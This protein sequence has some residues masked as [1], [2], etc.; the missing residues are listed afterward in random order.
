MTVMQ[1]LRSNS[2]KVTW[3][4]LVPVVLAFTMFG[5]GLSLDAVF[6][7]EK[8]KE[9]YVID[10]V[11]VTAEEHHRTQRIWSAIRSV[12]GQASSVS[13]DEVR[14]IIGECI[15][16]KKLGFVVTDAE[17]DASIYKEFGGSQQSYEATLRRMGLSGDDIRLWFQ[18]K[19][20]REKYS[21][22]QRSAIVPTAS[23]IYKKFDYDRTNY[24]IKY[25][26]VRPEDFA[27]DVI[28][29][30]EKL[31]EFYDSAVAKWNT[32][33]DKRVELKKLQN[34]FTA[35]EEEIKALKEEVKKLEEDEIIKKCDLVDGPFATVHFVY[36]G[37]EDVKK[38]VEV[39]SMS[40][41]VKDFYFGRLD[42]YRK[43]DLPAVPKYGPVAPEDPSIMPPVPANQPTE[44]P[45]N[46]ATQPVVTPENPDPNAPVPTELPDADNDAING[47]GEAS[48]E[49]KPISYRDFG[50]EFRTLDEVR[51]QVV[52][53]LID[54]KSHDKSEEILTEV[55]SL[56]AQMDLVK[57]DFSIIDKQL[58]KKL[59]SKFPFKIDEKVITPQNAEFIETYGSTDL[60]LR[61]FDDYSYW[62][63]FEEDHL[64]NFS[65]V[66]TVASGKYIF[67]VKKEERANI[68]SFEDTKTVVET[69]YRKIEQ[70]RIAKETAEN[71]IKSLQS[72]KEIGELGPNITWA[73]AKGTKATILYLR[74]FGSTGFKEGMISDKPIWIEDQKEAY[75]RVQVLT[76][77]DRPEIAGFDKD[78]DN[79]RVRCM[80]DLLGTRPDQ[81]KGVLGKWQRHNKRLFGMK[82][83]EETEE[84]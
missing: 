46:P 37:F 53:D 77:I 52:K 44:Q 64:D 5:L 10:G 74:E 38:T 30:D 66:V 12:S 40:D 29:N 69:A 21:N 60:K 54:V 56:I 14:E 73:D 72:G 6:G 58:E 43:T 41:E 25:T 26:V 65:D 76:K 80:S 78:F 83:E 63:H 31:K 28:V 9:M 24:T 75:W 35:A 81:P 22:F 45:Q 68:K 71:I 70:K 82:V 16:A 61:A 19:T 62:K 33:I 47:N 32:L 67:F 48:L 42:K 79:F 1:M 55:R 57:Y 2:R 7:N 34:S 8:G 39:D 15:L 11:K 4:I 3:F 18:Q 17:I 36:V 13:E 23:D 49:N 84:N 27:D 20:L 51:E 59:A 50:S